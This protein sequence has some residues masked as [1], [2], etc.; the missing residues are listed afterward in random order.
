MEKDLSFDRLNQIYGKLLTDKQREITDLY[1]SCD[2]SLAEIAEIKG[3]SRSACLDNI[4]SAKRH[5]L[6]YE[7]ELKILKMRKEIAEVLS[8]D[9]SVE[10]LKKKINEILGE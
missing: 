8:L 6:K 9:C 10:E 7:N 4:E 2:L 5:L 1:Y 3:I